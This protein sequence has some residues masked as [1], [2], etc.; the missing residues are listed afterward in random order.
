[1]VAASA[2]PVSD[3]REVP[4]GRQRTAGAATPMDSRRAAATQSAA[5]ATHFEGIL[6]TPDGS[7]GASLHLSTRELPASKRLPALQE[8]FDQS[9][10]MQ[11]EAEPGVAVEM[12]MAIAPG[13]RR[14]KL[15]TA[16]TARVARPAQRLADGEDAV[17][18]MVKTGGHIALAQGR[19]ESVPQVD[20]GVLLVYRQPALLQFVAATYLSVRVPFGAV[21]ALAPVE[22]AAALCIPRRT[23]ALALLR[24]YVASLPE[25]FDDPQLCRLAAMHVYDLVALAIGATDEGRELAS[26]RGVRAARLA[27]IKSCL[28][29]DATLPIGQVA[30]SQGVSVR[31]VQMLFE[32]QGTTYSDYALER[33]LDAARRMLASPRY[34]SQSIAAI[35]L[36]AGFGD[37][38]HFNRRFKRRYQMT[39]S[40]ARAR[41]WGA[42]GP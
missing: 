38:S 2:A 16:L 17:C 15:V 25:R 3:R 18:L 14:A 8:L 35:A 21:A 12:Q 40:E 23:G 7:C 31:Y 26:R 34:V 19:R 36:E 27:A 41:G 1:M 29:T 32:E 13:M 30:A 33:R 9:I 24:A 22:R 42:D 20:D 6:M 10:R 39:P 5:R 11:L 28:A 37:V 4:I